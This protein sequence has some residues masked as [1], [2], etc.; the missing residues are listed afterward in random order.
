MAYVG[1]VSIGD[2]TAI[3]PNCAFYAYN[4]GINAGELIKRQ[5][6][7][8]RGDIVIGDG[9]WIGFGVVVLDGVTIGD[10]AVVGAGAVVTHDVPENAIVV[11]NPARVVSHRDNPG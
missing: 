5:P 10:G 7:E 2:H 11:G 9:V 1:N 4:H 8:S 6:L 3:A